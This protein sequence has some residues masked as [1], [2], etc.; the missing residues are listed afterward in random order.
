MVAIYNEQQTAHPEDALNMIDLTPT[1]RLEWL[2]ERNSLTDARDT[3]KKLLEKYER[4]LETTNAPESELITRFMD[5]EQSRSYMESAY[6]FGDLVYEALTK[7]G[8]DT[9]FHRLLVV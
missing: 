9:R 8:K 4:F 5:K 6:Q 1:Q 7:I 3:I 2:Q